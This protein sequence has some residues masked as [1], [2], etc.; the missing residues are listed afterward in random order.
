MPL[1]ENDQDWYPR[2]ADRLQWRRVGKDTLVLHLTLKQYHILNHV[3][4]RIWELC[5]G[6]RSNRAISMTLAEE[7]NADGQAVLD[8]VTSTLH[9]F[10]RIG[11]LETE[12]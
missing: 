7:F 12:A 2:R 10:Q 4:G 9:G 1:A 11:I 5:D 6:K 3:A 8:D